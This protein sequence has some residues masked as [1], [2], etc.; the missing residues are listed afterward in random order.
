M[1]W[2]SG[3]HNRCSMEPPLYAVSPHLVGTSSQTSQA[4]LLINFSLEAKSTG[5]VL[6]VRLERLKWDRDSRKR[7]QKESIS[8][9]CRQ[10]RNQGQESELL[11]QTGT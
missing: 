7:T 6:P 4:A 11:L 3:G 5:M 9:G 10:R 8:I 1:E 2:R